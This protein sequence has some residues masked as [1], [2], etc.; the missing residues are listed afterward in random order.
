MLS[1]RRQSDGQTVTA[2][3]E[4]KANGPFSCL[5]CGD[6][7]LLKGGKNQ[8][9]HFAHANPIACKFAEGESDE[10]RRCKMEIYEALLQQPHVRNVALERP[11]G[12]VRPDISAYV[13]GVPVAIEVQI[14]ALSMETILRRTIDYYR[15]GIYVLWLLPWTPKL[16]AGRYAPTAWEKWIH[17]ANFGHVYY[18]TDGLN[19][20][21]Y[22][23][24]ASYRTVPQT[25]WFAK[26]G[27]K[28]TGGGYNRKSDRYRTPVREGTF[29]LAT[30]FVP[31]ER[32]W[33]S[34][35]DIKVPDA[36][37]FVPSAFKP[38]GKQRKD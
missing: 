36:K 21:S 14:S 19:V 10:H 16:D 26:N 4:S 33:W 37:I 24:D 6:P 3:F 11:L 12:S 28:M 25:T 5:V 31:A 38:N 35:G 20:V 22:H 17:A 15:Q 30:D 2:Y 13:N 27:K 32:F 29:N 7:V 1:A 34:S 9:N 23:F 18:W 8:I